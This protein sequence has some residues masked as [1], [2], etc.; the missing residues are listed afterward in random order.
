MMWEVTSN[1]S[2]DEIIQPHLMHAFDRQRQLFQQYNARQYTSRLAI[3]MYESQFIT[4]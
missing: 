2:R 1:D 4:A 3:L